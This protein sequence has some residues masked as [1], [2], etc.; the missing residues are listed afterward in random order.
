M[1]WAGWQTTIT[2]HKRRLVLPGRYGQDGDSSLPPEAAEA[3]CHG[4]TMP[5]TGHRAAIA[6]AAPAI[7]ATASATTVPAAAGT[8]G[9]TPASTSSTVK[10]DRTRPA[11]AANRRHQ[12]RTVSAGRPSIAATARTPEP[13]ALAASAA[14]ITSARSARRNSTLT[15]SRT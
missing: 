13:R 4:G 14:P 5:I 11:L 9:S 8:T 6:A 2:A 15:G 12:P 7:A 3:A 10:N 1:T